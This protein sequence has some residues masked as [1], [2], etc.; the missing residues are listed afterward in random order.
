MKVDTVLETNRAVSKHLLLQGPHS[1][2]HLRQYFPLASFPVVLGG[3]QL[4]VR[5]AVRVETCRDSHAE[6]EKDKVGLKKN[7]FKAWHEYS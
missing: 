1:V 7:F 4:H 6:D 3:V 2:F 5:R